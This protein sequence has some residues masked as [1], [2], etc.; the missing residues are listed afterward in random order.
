MHVTFVQPNRAYLFDELRIYPSA[1]KLTLSNTCKLQ[2]CKHHSFKEYTDADI[3]IEHNMQSKPSGAAGRGSSNRWN[4]F[5]P[6]DR[7][8]ITQIFLHISFGLPGFFGPY[9]SQQ[10][11]FLTLRTTPDAETLTLH[12]FSWQLISKTSSGVLEHFQEITSG[13]LIYPISCLTIFE[14]EHFLSKEMDTYIYV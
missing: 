6:K 8:Q 3:Q 4:I 14:S 12:A 7:Q 5:H 10:L 2:K 9:L 1:L 13:V 11:D